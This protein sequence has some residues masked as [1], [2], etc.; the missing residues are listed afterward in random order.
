M[1]M[2]TIGVDAHKALHVAVAIDAAGEQIG[3]WRGANGAAG[4]AELLTCVN[5]P[6]SCR[7]SQRRKRASCVVASSW[8]PRIISLAVDGA[9]TKKRVARVL[10]TT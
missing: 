9:S 3:R 10:L 6:S 1:G 4:W 5:V 2:P 7:T 8:R